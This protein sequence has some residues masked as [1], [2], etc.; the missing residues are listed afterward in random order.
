M[1]WQSILV[2]AVA[3]CTLWEGC[4]ERVAAIASVDAAQPRTLAGARRLL[5][6]VILRWAASRTPLAAGQMLSFDMMDENHDGSLDKEE[7]MISTRDALDSE[8][9]DNKDFRKAVYSFAEELYDICDVDN[10]GVLSELEYEYGRHLAVAGMSAAHHHQAQLGHRYFSDQQAMALLRAMD[11]SGDGV[12]DENEFQDGCRHALRSLH[13]LHPNFDSAF[14][15]DWAAAIFS[16]ADITSDASLS[17]HEVQYGTLLM[18]MY[19]LEELSGIVRRDLDA[20]SD[21]RLD[22]HE[23]TF[24][25]ESSKLKTQLGRSLRQQLHDGFD[26]ADIDADGSLDDE[27]ISGLV[28]AV[29]ARHSSA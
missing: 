1:A 21:G 26:S 17:A 6:T 11:S 5:V 12:V 2:I 22:R 8:G 24:G 20:N 15:E 13:W 4:G 28:G 10:D 19:V 29:L 9:R 14:V 25:V 27:E 7:F 16:I 23:L 3:M 18:N